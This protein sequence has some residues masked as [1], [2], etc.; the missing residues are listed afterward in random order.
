MEMSLQAPV[1]GDELFGDIDQAYFER[2]YI[3]LNDETNFPLMEKLLRGQ[4]SAGVSEERRA[5][6]DAAKAIQNGRIKY[7]KNGWEVVT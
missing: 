5:L 2:A 4:G 1:S 3:F 7:G 6:Y